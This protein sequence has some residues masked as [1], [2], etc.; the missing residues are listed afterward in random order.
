MTTRPETIIREVYPDSKMSPGGL[1]KC[2]FL[3]LKFQVFEQW[4]QQKQAQFVVH[5][6]CNII[7][8]KDCFSYIV[9]FKNSH[10][11]DEKKKNILLMRHSVLVL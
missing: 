9:L 6:S 11:L 5:I 4:Q 10:Y 8:K 1:E 7:P 2:V 3:P